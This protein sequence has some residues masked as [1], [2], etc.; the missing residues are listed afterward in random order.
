MALPEAGEIVPDHLHLFIVGPGWGETVLVRIPADRWI[1]IDSLEFG[2]PRRPA[3]EAIVSR[4]GGEVAILALTHPHQD[5]HR[6]FAELIDRYDDA[7][8][9]CVQPRDAGA[10]G[11]LPNDA[12][13]ALKEQAK[14][15]FKRIRDKWTKEPN[16]R[17]DTFRGE[18]RE[19]GEA[20]VTALH[21]VDPVDAR[22][23]S[24]DL[25]AISSA[26]LVEWHGLRLL[27]GAD[28]PATEWTEIADAFPKLVGNAFGRLSDHTAMKVPHH[29][30]RDAMHDA[31]G[32]GALGRFWVITPLRR[33]WRLPRAEDF[34]GR[35][36]AEGLSRA[37]SFVNEVRLTSLPFAHQQEEKDPWVTTRGEIRDRPRPLGPVAPREDDNLTARALDRQVVVAFDRHGRVAN[38]WYGRGTVRVGR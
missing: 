7:V 38:E 17:W 20:T 1:I 11:L 16:R 12:E 24:K 30:S 13:A 26:M 6:G 8:L 10:P 23:W 31:F 33:R 9:G 19:V 2:T 32:E 22:R 36:E 28:V 37:L 29:G 25:N 34:T 18:S 14:A 27:L 3:A 4:Y 21:P 5:H 15:V 35:G